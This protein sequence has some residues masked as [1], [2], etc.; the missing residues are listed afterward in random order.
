M[1]GH[2]GIGLMGEKLKKVIGTK[3]KIVSNDQK[4]T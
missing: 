1:L 4:K 2:K 3:R